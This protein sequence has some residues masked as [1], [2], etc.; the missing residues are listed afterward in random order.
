MELFDATI[1]DCANNPRPLQKY[2]QV[3]SCVL[4]RFT[5]HLHPYLVTIYWKNVCGRGTD[6]ITLGPYGCNCVSN[7]ILSSIFF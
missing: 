5:L 4:Y 2:N 6:A 1:Y 3:W 7:V